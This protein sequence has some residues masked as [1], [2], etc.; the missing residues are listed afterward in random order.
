MV[1]ERLRVFGYVRVSTD[2]QLDN[3]SIEEQTER[4]KAFCKANVFKSC[5]KNE[6][7]LCFMLV[8]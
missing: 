6:N 2:N 7:F 8:W 5:T 1:K 4:I 3:Y